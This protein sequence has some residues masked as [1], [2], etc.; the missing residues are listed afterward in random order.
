MHVLNDPSN[1]MLCKTFN[2]SSKIKKMNS[3]VIETAG[4]VADRFCSE[5]LIPVS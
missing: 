4:C 2:F 5:I 3:V 1:W